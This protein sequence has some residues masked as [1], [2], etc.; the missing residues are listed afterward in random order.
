MRLGESSKSK[1][2]PT[3]K[4]YPWSNQKLEKGYVSLL[5]IMLRGITNTWKFMIKINSLY[6]TYTNTDADTN[7]LFWLKIS[8]KMPK[9]GFEW[10]GRVYLT[11]DFIKLLWW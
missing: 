4:C 11:K 10:A 7:Q 2:T 3:I 1:F 6:L 5:F 9:G 8:Q